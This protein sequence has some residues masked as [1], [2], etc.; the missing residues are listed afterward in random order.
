MRSAGRGRSA[1]AHTRTAGAAEPLVVLVEFPEPVRPVADI[2]AGGDERPV[3][4][5]DGAP[6][7]GG[8]PRRRDRGR[9]PGH[10]GRGSGPVVRL[11][12]GLLERLAALGVGGFLV[13]ADRAL[14]RFD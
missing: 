2:A 6:D 14:D 9:V 5:L 1:V 8:K 10:G 7:F 3:E 11:P 4:V 12:M 13:A